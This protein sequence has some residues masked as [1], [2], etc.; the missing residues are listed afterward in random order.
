MNEKQLA[1]IGP[2]LCTEC[3]AVVPQA[4]NT[5]AGHPRQVCWPRTGSPRE[6][7]CYYARKTRIDKLSRERRKAAR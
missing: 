1:E 2:V 7:K 5:R 3:S 4:A 6:S